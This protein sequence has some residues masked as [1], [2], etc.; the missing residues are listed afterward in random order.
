M[1]TSIECK[2][3]GIWKITHPFKCVNPCPDMKIIHKD[4][5]VKVRNEW[6]TGFELWINWRP[7]EDIAGPWTMV[8]EFKEPLDTAVEYFVWQTRLT[9]SANGRV[10]T[11]TS[12]PY[13]MGLKAGELYR[14]IMVISGAG[15]KQLPGYKVSYTAG[16]YVDMS[17]LHE[18]NYDVTTS[19]LV[20]TTTQPQVV[21][22]TQP[23]EEENPN[24]CS[25]KKNGF[26]VHPDCDKYYHCYS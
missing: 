21:T 17:C 26:Y 14:V 15:R 13:N 11:M 19:T 6:P 2:W 8:F 16:E 5:Y 24:F 1:R 23:A 9:V 20:P 10:A 12:M 18:N 22:T 25:G 3:T 7:T 4:K